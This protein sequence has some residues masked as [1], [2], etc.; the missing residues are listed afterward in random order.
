MRNVELGRGKRQLIKSGKLH[1]RYAI[2]IPEDFGAE[3]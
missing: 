2:T 3:H 1:A